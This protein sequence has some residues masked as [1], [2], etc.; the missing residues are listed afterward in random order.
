MAWL[1]TYGL[2]LRVR[3]LAEH[4]GTEQTRDP[5]RNT[6]TTAAGLLARMTV[7]PLRVNYHLEHH[8]L[9][10]VPWYRLPALHALLRARG[11]LDG[12]MVSHGYLSVLRTATRRSDA[13]A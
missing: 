9:V 4:A 3:A 11:A 10:A 1:T 2:F 12:A 6:R 7:A 13:R 5:F 8:L